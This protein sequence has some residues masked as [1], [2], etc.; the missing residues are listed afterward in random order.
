[1]GASGTEQTVEL[2]SAH[3]RA[4]LRQTEG[5][6]YVKSRFLAEE[7]SDACQRL[8]EQMQEAG[9]RGIRAQPLGMYQYVGCPPPVRLGSPRLSTRG[10]NR[11]AWFEEVC[12]SHRVT[13][14]TC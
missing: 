14:P 11:R 8:A 9:K 5:S 7:I 12:C 13:N 4:E 2:V 3:L 6:L 1:M 10:S